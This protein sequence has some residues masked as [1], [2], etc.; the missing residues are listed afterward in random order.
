MPRNTPEG[1]LRN[2]YYCARE[3]PCGLVALRDYV[4]TVDIVVGIRGTAYT[5]RYSFDNADI[6]R[7]ALSKWDGNGDPPGPWLK[8]K[9]VDET[10]VGPGWAI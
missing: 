10:R 7:D 8:Y 2:G 6:A 5:G 4:H 3:L 1:L 9:G